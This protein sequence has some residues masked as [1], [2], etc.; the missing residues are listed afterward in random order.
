[1]VDNSRNSQLF[2][3][4]K[5]R[6]IYD[7]LIQKHLAQYRQM[8]FMVGPRQV[9]K[10]T[11]SKH[12]TEHT[13][14]HVSLNWDYQPD[15]SLILRGIEAILEQ[16]PQLLQAGTEKALLTLDEIHKY[17][18]W[19]NFVKGIYDKHSEV[20]SIMVTGSA[21]LDV[22]RT[23]GDSLMGRYF[24]YRI[25][26]LSIAECVRSTLPEKNISLPQAV[27]KE[28]VDQLLDF[29]GFVEPFLHQSTN[30]YNRWSTLRLDQLFLEDI[31][32]L[33]RIQEIAELKL[34]T[35]LLRE[36]SGNLLNYTTLSKHCRVSVDTIQKWML[37]L[38][39]FYYCFLIKPWT[40]NISRSLLKQPKVYLWDWS[41]VTDLGAKHENFVAGH[42]LKFVQ[43]CNDS[44]LGDY[45]LYFLRDKDK[46]EIDF[47]VTDNQ[48]PWFL[49]EVK[50][51]STQSI[52]ENLYHFQ[53]LT[54]ARHAFQVVFDLPYVDKNCFDYHDPVIVPVST[55]LSQLV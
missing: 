35:Q 44:G 2:N 6:R 25:H 5:M 23:A 52:S 27:S 19:R 4:F 14:R 42:L 17:K 45:E 24:P 53:K 26:P 20:L 32:D 12:A 41:F 54:N 3:G 37:T 31:R 38:S 29:S 30:F 33:T 15:Q 51:K 1:M 22:F 50:A 39:S 48:K 9:G 11:L 18:N 49:V 21:Q 8:V 36:Y 16:Y 46:R 55:F 40:T 43:F 34:L 13:L 10:T 7:L 28:L 47:L